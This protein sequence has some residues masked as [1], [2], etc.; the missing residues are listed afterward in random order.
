MLPVCVNMLSICPRSDGEFMTKIPLYVYKG[1]IIFLFF[2]VATIVSH[3]GITN[4]L[5]IAHTAL[6]TP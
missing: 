1:G 3:C 6:K 5:L 4:F 2:T